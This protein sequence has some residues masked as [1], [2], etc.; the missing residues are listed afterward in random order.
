M[1]KL[2][3]FFS[4]LSALNDWQDEVE[5]A[6]KASAQNSCCPRTETVRPTQQKRW[7]P[8]TEPVVIKRNALVLDL[9]AYRE[10]K[11]AASA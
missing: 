4:S 2:R 6:L 10:K 5:H 8:S 1:S 11:E 9:N 7:T 3:D